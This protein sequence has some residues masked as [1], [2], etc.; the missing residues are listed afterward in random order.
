MKFNELKNVI[1]TQ[2]DAKKFLADNK[3]GEKRDYH[4]IYVNGL[5]TNW[6]K[7]LTFAKVAYFAACGEW[8]TTCEYAE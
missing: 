4:K 5:A 6:A 1:K 2:N 3:Y 7:N 8:P